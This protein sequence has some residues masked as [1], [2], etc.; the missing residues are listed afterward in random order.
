[1]KAFYK[2][3]ENPTLKN[4]Q[5]RSLSQGKSESFTSF[6]NRVEKE[7]GHCQFKCASPDCTAE[8]KAVRD[9]IV[10]GTL[11]NEIR[12][13][14]LKKSW[15]LSLLRTE[16]MQM[17]SAHKGASQITEANH[18]KIGKYSIRNQKNKRD[19]PAAKKANCYFC[20]LEFERRDIVAHSSQCPSKTGACSKC[21]VFG[22]SAKVFKN[23]KPVHEISQRNKTK[24]TRRP[25]I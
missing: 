19:P 17:E 24:T 3:T 25:T 8:Q 2:P 10:I 16:G 13:E 5:F 4:Y 14:A 12:E 20:G 23:V 6:C 9:Q 11:M 18:N 15:S 22:H 21:K 7:A 1:M